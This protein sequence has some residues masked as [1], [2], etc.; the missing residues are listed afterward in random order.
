M[1]PAA[2]AAINCLQ[3]DMFKNYLDEATCTPAQMVDSVLKDLHPDRPRS[4]K[5]SIKSAGESVF[6]DMHVVDSKTLYSFSFS[7][8]V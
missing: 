3:I 4:G 6:A 2:Y 8:V 1:C 5:D 7:H